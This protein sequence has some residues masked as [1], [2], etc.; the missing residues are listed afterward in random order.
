MQPGQL[1]PGRRLCDTRPP[2]GPARPS[3]ATCISVARQAPWTGDAGRDVAV[4]LD[5]E[6][7]REWRWCC[8]IPPS[9]HS[10]GMTLLDDWHRRLAAGQDR[11]MCTDAAAAR[12]HLSSRSQSRHPAV[13][14]YAGRSSTRGS[15]S[16]WPTCSAGSGGVAERRGD[17]AVGRRSRC[18]LSAEVPKLATSVARRSPV[19]AGAGLDLDR[20]CPGRGVGVVGMISPADSR[21]RRWSS[22]RIARA[23]CSRSHGFPF[24]SGR[25]GPGAIS[26]SPADLAVVRCRQVAAGCPVMGLRF[27]GDLAVG[28]R[29]DTC[30]AELGGVHP[31]SSRE[32][33]GAEREHRR[34]G[35][36]SRSST[37]STS[38]SQLLRPDPGAIT[39][40]PGQTARGGPPGRRAHRGRDVGR[41]RSVA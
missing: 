16:R 19:A 21:S 13:V 11:L 27:T 4:L 32:A 22:R 40:G 15:R 35:G 1:Q 6:R 38:G 36:R 31:W 25:R 8:S 39:A 37:F 17:S 26:L 41:V 34:S 7:I 24:P 23:E 29:F 28:D 18:A 10:D 12:R 14:G 20:S 33:F 3:G 9:V 2:R 5:G 30:G